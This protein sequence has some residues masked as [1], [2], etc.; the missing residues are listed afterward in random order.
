MLAP[1][2]SR[3][4]SLSLSTTKIPTNLVIRMSRT[5]LYY[6]TEWQIL[7]SLRFLTSTD[8]EAM[9]EAKARLLKRAGGLS[10]RARGPNRNFPLVP[11]S[12]C[13]LGRME[14][15]VP[16][17]ITLPGVAKQNMV[18]LVRASN[19]DGILLT[20]PE[21]VYYASGLPVLPGSGNPI[22]FALRNQLPAFVY[23]DAAGPVTLFCWIGA[24][25]GFSFPVDE[26][27]SFFNQESALA[28]LSDFLRD[29][30]KPA[31]RVG[32]E[33]CCPLSVARQLQEL[34]PAEALTFIDEQFLSLRL[35]KTPRELALIRRATGIAEATTADLRAHLKPGL[36]RLE[37]IQL[38]KRLLLEHGATGIGHTTIAFGTSNPEIARDEILQENQLVTLDL[39]ASVESYVSDNRRLFY[40]GEIPASLLALHQS[41]CEI[42]EQVGQALRPGVAFADL[43]A[44]AAD[45]YNAHGLPPLFLSIGHSIGLQTEEV[46]ITP[47]SSLTV[48]PDMVLNIELYTAWEDGSSIGD[49]ETLVI[50]GEGASR[51]TQSDSALQSV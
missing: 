20:S 22:L 41:M 30:L 46:W 7:H 31:S 34:L 13:F 21:N 43:Y 48:Q 11:L 47:D 32:I 39:G 5:S 50:T 28:E 29:T 37:L 23:L 38:A 24:T 33:N 27:R 16:H 42:V 19:L 44:L 51:L 49:E 6:A 35:R 14:S 3:R 45:L 4:Y 12:I 40:T 2:P 36:A 8:Q 10:E 1:V 17:Q 18:E 25:M 15:T 9:L 26:V